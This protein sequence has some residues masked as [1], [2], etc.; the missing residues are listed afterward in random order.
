MNVFK[1]RRFFWTWRKIDTNDALS[2][3]CFFPQWF[4]VEGG[5][6][7]WNVARTCCNCCKPQRKPLFNRTT[8]NSAT[9]CTTVSILNFPTVVKKQSVNLFVWKCTAAQ[10]IL[11]SVFGSVIPSL[12]NRPTVKDL[13]Q[14][15]HDICIWNLWVLYCQEI[16]SKNEWCIEHFS[17]FIT[18]CWAWTSK[19]CWPAKKCRQ[20]ENKELQLLSPP[21]SQIHSALILSIFI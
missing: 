18:S 16:L 11:V 5:S 3:N 9:Q 21:D 10:L 20:K 8:P 15:N 13:A 4:R 19:N 1:D 17:N 7:T 14:Y 6:S 2:P 12:N